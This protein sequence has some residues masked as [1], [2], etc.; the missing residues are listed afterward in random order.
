MTSLLVEPHVSL[1][2]GAEFPRIYTVPSC[3][4]SSGDEAVELA[5]MAGLTLDGW[6]EFVLAQSLGE[7]EAQRWAAFEVGLSCARQNGKNEILVARELAGLFLLGERLLIHTAHEAVTSNE[8]F[9]RLLDVIE[10]TP[11]FMRRV[12]DIKKG[13]GQE[14]LELKNGQR[15]QFK[16]RTKSAGRGFT[17]DLLVLDEAMI[18]PESSYGA[19]LPTLSAR[20][21]SQ[22]WFTGSAVD[23][24]VHE[25]GVVFARVRERGIQG[26]PSLAYFEFSAPGDNPSVMSDDELDS[27]D[28]WALANPGLGVRISADHVGKE[29]RSMDP[30]TFAVERLGVGDWPRT[31]GLDGVV[32][33]P[34]DWARCIDPESRKTGSVCFSLDVS[35]D[36]AYGAIGVSGW[37]QDGRVHVEVVEHRRGTGWMVDRMVELVIAHKPLAVILDASGAVASLVPELVEGLRESDNGNLL[38]SLPEK[39]LSLVSA[40]DH[41]QAC[42]M[43]YDAVAQDTIR[44]LG[45]LELSAAIAGAVKRPLGDSWAW[46]RKNSAIDISPLVAVTLA[47]W[48][49]FTHGRQVE[50][51]VTDL[52]DILKGMQDKGEDPFNL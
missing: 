26:D 24:E 2:K 36:R 45:T 3:V 21:N 48:G 32:I 34:E 52:S 9:R 18:I 44:H 50:P 37:R 39:E 20:P 22:I 41:A 14:G 49:S 42:G 38:L 47:L 27:L 23:K 5:R 11:S 4:R 51:K 33:T 12:K 25:D 10:D 15:I 46:S 29:R 30:R 43:I 35:P 19:L 8:A 7:T 13:K 16:T 17:A 1:A 40:R 6:Q 28:N 31:D